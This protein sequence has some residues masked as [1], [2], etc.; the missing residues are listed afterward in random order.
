MATIPL[1]HSPTRTAV[2][3]ALT[4][5][6]ASR[7]ANASLVPTLYRLGRELLGL[8][9]FLIG[10]AMLFTLWLIPLG[11]PVVLVGLALMI[12]SRK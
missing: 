3:K 10:S 5:E 8:I 11:L 9:L 6:T 4:V 2:R 1:D 12:C 7:P